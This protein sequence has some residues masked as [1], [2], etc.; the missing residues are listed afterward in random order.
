MKK[1]FALFAAVFALAAFAAQDVKEAQAPGS[2]GPKAAAEKKH[3]KKTHGIDKTAKQP[4]AQKA[5]SE[6]A[7][8]AAEAKHLKKAHGNLPADSSPKAP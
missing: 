5:G 1:V 4:E 7:Q 3:L 2:E 6:K 8:A